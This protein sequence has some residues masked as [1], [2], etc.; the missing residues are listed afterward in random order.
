[1]TY[2]FMGLLVALA[3]FFDLSVWMWLRANPV[4]PLAEVPDWRVRRPI[5]RS[6]LNDYQLLGS[7]AAT[8]S[9]ASSAFSVVPGAT[10]QV[11]D[12]SEVQGVPEVT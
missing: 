7:M 11:Q 4:P 6:D 1:M 3:L 5:T 10:W 2:V 9:F 12:P 8:A